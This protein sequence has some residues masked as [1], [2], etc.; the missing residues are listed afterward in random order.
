MLVCNL[1]CGDDT[2][3]DYRVDINKTK[4]TIHVFNVEKGIKFDDNMFDEV[5]SRNLLEHLR[6]VG[7]HLDECFRVLKKGG[8]INIITDNA[9]CIRYYI[10]GT[11]TGRYEKLSMPNDRHFEVFTKSHLLNHFTVAGFTDVTL[12][13]IATDTNGRYFDMLTLNLLG[14]PRIQVIAW[15]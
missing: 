1:G 12:K 8:K 6:N 3:G 7:Y 4:A 14:R 13:Y 9:E 10:F 11:H 2:Y 15:K 5:C